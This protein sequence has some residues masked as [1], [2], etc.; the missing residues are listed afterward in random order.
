MSRELR[1]LYENEGRS[2]VSRA[3][4]SELV[5]AAAEGPRAS[6]RFAFVAAAAVSGMA[7]LANSSEIVATFLAKVASALETAL[8][9]QMEDS[10]ASSNLVQVLAQLYMCNA[11]KPDIIYS[12]MERWLREFSEIEIA[13]MA[14]L[15]SA[16]GLALRAADPER[17]RDFVLAVHARAGEVETLSMRARVM[18]DLVVDIKNNRKRGAMHG[19]RGATAV[20]PA[21][22]K[23]LRG[24]GVDGVAVGGISWDKIVQEDKRG[25]W[26]MP[27]AADAAAARGGDAVLKQLPDVLGGTKAAVAAIGSDAGV[28]APELLKLAAAM[29]M[30]T[31]SRRAVFC[32]V[33]GSEDAVDALEKLLR[34]NLKGQQER[35]V[36]RVTVDCCLHEASWNP[37]YAHLL[38]RLCGTSKGHKMTFQFCLWDHFKEI[39]GMQLRRLTVL[40]RLSAA[41]VS[42]GALPLSILKVVDFSDVLSAR[43]VMF[44][45]L[46]FEH[47][48]YG[49]RKDEDVPALFE[50]GVTRGTARPLS[51]L[52]GSL[53]AFLKRNVGPWLAMKD[54]KDPSNGGPERLSLLLRRCRAAERALASTE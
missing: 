42:S 9:R 11:L 19:G 12:L 34:L 41:A 43:E 46:F 40:A 21:T 35:E 8:Q 53:L 44:W 23:W 29:R 48:L 27:T 4:S 30:N 7:A 32:A 37:Y 45:R 31:D 38:T 17:M 28:S 2:V 18:L 51:G 49:C 50:R 39:S 36:V 20:P 24:L 13:A 1:E 47:M 14:T 26:W 22:A 10:L 3:V 33:M 15:L 52:R 54:P 25:M 6:E 5:S 16:A